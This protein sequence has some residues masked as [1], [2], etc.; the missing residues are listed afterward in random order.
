MFVVMFGHGLLPYLTV[1]RSFKDPA[2]HAGF[3]GLAVFLYAFAMQAFFTTAGFTAA[4][5]LSRRGWVGLWKNRWQRIAAPLLVGYVVLSPLT[6][7]A[8]TFAKA[9]V[10]DSSFAA[11]VDALASLSW[12][13]WSKLYHL[14]F[15]AS[16]LLFT[17]LLMVLVKSGLLARAADAFA[18]R[19]RRVLLSPWRA[20]WW[21][22][23]ISVSTVPAYVFGAGSGTAVWMQLTM[24]AFFCLGWLLQRHPDVLQQIAI[25]WRWQIGLALALLPLCIWSTRA[26]L[27]AEDQSDLWVGSLAGVSNAAIAALMTFG[28]LGLFWRHLNR[29]TARLAALGSASYWVYLVHLPI[30]VAAGGAVSVL[31]APVLVKYVLSMLLASLVIAASYRVLVV[32]TPLASVL[33]GKRAQSD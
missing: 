18:A 22:L 1:P 26:R 11:G 14:W 7:A 24:F 27:F 4:L 29:P 2:H 12:L 33:M 32:G 25:D 31:A 3:D 9:C 17:A 20:F 21:A 15:L 10:A 8:Y 6:L 5:V 19:A 13:R 23:L 28:L 30:V 16:L